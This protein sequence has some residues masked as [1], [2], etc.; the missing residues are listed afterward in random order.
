MWTSRSEPYRT[1]SFASFDSLRHGVL[2]ENPYAWPSDSSSRYQYSRRELDHGAMAPS[3]IDR[4][5]SGMTSSGSTSRRV[6]SP[7]HVGHAP[8]GELN[9]KLR[10]AS[11]SNEMPSY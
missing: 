9:E 2:V 4:S 11:S 6:P 3:S 5:A 10:G 1:A 7:S 8:Y